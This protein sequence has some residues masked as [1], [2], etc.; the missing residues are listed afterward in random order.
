MASFVPN[1]CRTPTYVGCLARR[2]PRA[3]RTVR[4]PRH[5][6]RRRGRVAQTDWRRRRAGRR[7]RTPKGRRRTEPR[8]AAVR[9]VR[10]RH[11]VRHRPGPASTGS[12]GLRPAHCGQSD[13]HTKRVRESG[14]I[15]IL[16]EAGAGLLRLGSRREQTRDPRRCP[17]HPGAALRLARGTWSSWDQGLSLAG[18]RR[19]STARRLLERQCPSGRRRL[20]RGL[21]SVTENRN[22]RTARC[23]DSEGAPRR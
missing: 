21:R 15:R 12:E 18:L 9:R 8:R 3:H 20:L 16:V 17:R 22:R 2:R 5:H 23:G 1:T 7:L 14:G 6:R 4:S 13:R 19:V 10:L 11:R